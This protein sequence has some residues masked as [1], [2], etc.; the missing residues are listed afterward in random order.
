MQHAAEQLAKLE[1]VFGM[2]YDRDGLP[3]LV[4][5]ILEQKVSLA[6]ALAVLAR[7][8]GLCGSAEG[9][10]GELITPG[11]WLSV[12]A[13][14]LYAAGV[15]RRKIEYCTA[16][17]QAIRNGTVSLANLQHCDDKRVVASLTAVRGIGPW[18]ANVY[19]MMCLLRPDAWAT[20]DRALAVAVKECFAM[21]DVPRYP[22]LDRMALAWRPHRA[23]AA[24][25][26][27]QAYLIKRNKPLTASTLP[28]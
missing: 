3:A 28:Q 24:R 12:S 1:P 13:D 14:E 5:I 26:L 8:R 17:A 27:W 2:L 18:T 6:S 10:P 15:S 9:K 25:L 22:E 4:H 20:G 19:N 16:L 7:V 11:S 21:A 23:T